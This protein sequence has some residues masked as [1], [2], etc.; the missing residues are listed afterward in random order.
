M[1]GLGDIGVKGGFEV[2]STLG[3]S[4]GQRPLGNGPDTDGATW[5]ERK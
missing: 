4:P 2:W 1:K 5:G 3:L